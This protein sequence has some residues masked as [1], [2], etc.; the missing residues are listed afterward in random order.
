MKSHLES[1]IMTDMDN[2][3]QIVKRKL[4]KLRKEMEEKDKIISDMKKK[5]KIPMA[6]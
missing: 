3:K 6:E 2:Q 5:Y 4:T 1:K